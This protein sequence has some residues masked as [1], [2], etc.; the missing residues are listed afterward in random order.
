MAAIPD[1]GG[2]QCAHCG[3]LRALLLG[4]LLR[5]TV[6]GGLVIASW[7]LSSGVAQAHEDSSAFSGLSVVNEVRTTPLSPLDAGDDD[8]GSDGLLGAAGTMRSTVADVVRAV[9]ALRSPVQPAHVPVLTP[10][11]EPVSKLAAPAAPNSGNAP[12]PHPAVHKPAALIAPAEPPA[13]VTAGAAPAPVHRM[14]SDAPSVTS[15]RVATHPVADPLTDRIA[16]P[17]AP[18]SGPTA[19]VPPSP[20]ATTTAPC[21]GGNAGGGSMTKGDPSVALSD[22]CVTTGLAP[23][24]YRLRA[25]A[26]GITPS[27][28][29]QPSTSPD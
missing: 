18:G 11:L 13:P 19:P 1:A 26:D 10:V 12:Q 24:H 28:A 22:E 23:T 4:A 9:P 7:L 25:G 21:V 6:L 27:T 2:A 15:V 14:V 17:S 20:P 5:V 8:D 29:Q 16:S 3:V